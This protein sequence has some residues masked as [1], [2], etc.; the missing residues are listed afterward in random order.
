LI[1]AQTRPP[2]VAHRRGSADQ[3]WLEL[4]VD[5]GVTA[6]LVYPFVELVE[7]ARGA[8]GPS[9]PNVASAGSAARSS[10]CTSKSRAR[11]EVAQ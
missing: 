2:E 10:R 7:H 11:P 1:A 6:G 5:H 4:L 3:P 8:F 9:C